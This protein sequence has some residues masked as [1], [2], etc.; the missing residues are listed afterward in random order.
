MHTASGPLYEVDT[1]LRPSGAQ[2]LLA[3]S[4]DSFARYQRE[5]AW[6]WEHLALTRARPVFGSAQARAALDA[7]L[8]ETLERPRDTEELTRQA[9]KMRGDIA[10]HKPPASDMD[11]KLVPG[12]LIDLEFLIHVSQFRHG[13][14]FDPDLSV[15][16][17]QLVEA[18]HLPAALIEAHDL[19]TRYLIVSRLVSPGSTEPP[20]ATRPLMARACGQADWDALLA[21][22]AKARQCVGDTW[23]AIAAPYQ[24][25]A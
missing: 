22:Y 11:V 6:T 5:E 8:K 17:S 21:S 19:I 4:L 3:V 7:V 9:V 20:E 23:A 24:E 25:D 1:R 16:L 13:M 14:A 2:G 15:A 10:R 18:G 12:G